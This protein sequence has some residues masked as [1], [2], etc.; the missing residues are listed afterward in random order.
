[1]LNEYLQKSAQLFKHL[2]KIPDDESRTE[3]IEKI[4][5]LLD[6]RGELVANLQKTG[7][8]FNQEDHTHN[9]LY[10]L[11][12]GIQERLALV[13]DTIKND[14]RDLQNT[15]KNERHY[16]DPYENLR[17]LEGRYYDGRK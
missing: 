10:E 2:T 15:K 8:T 13:M 3:Y 5:Q 16:I 1:M 9:T 6:E 11:D 7:F 12:K 14:I 4:N 17:I